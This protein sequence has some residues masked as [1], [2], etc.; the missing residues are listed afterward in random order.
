MRP[1]KGSVQHA[2]NTFYLATQAVFGFSVVSCDHHICE[3]NSEAHH[4]FQQCLQPHGSPFCLQA[5][6]PLASCPA[7]VAVLFL[8]GPCSA[9]ACSC[10]R[11]QA[12]LGPE[13][14][15]GRLYSVSFPAAQLTGMNKM[16]RSEL[17]QGCIAPCTC[18]CHW[19][20]FK[21]S[22]FWGI[23]LLNPK[24]DIMTS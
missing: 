9:T 13:S 1:P 8:L 15:H 19:P 14:A 11:C 20:C 10:L 21:A 23:L 2:K 16:A 7:I 6:L 22:G 5:R 17:A 24:D 4:L 18:Y 12:G 3:P